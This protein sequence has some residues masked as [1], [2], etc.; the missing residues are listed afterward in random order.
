M[1]RSVRAYAAVHR[2][3]SAL[4]LLAG[5]CLVGLL[6]ANVVLPS[7]A[8]TRGLLVALALPCACGVA[9]AFALVNDAPVLTPRRP[10]VVLARLGWVAVTL[11]A[12][13]VA[14]SVCAASSPDV[15]VAAVAR[16]VLISWSLAVVAVLVGQDELAWVIPTLVL[17]ASVLFSTPDPDL[18][19]EQ[20]WGLLLNKRLLAHDAAIALMFACPAAV[21]AVAFGDRKLPS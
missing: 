11:T 13:V 4:A 1:V 5:L 21:L 17:G 12:A 14:G 10:R 6:V 9:G 7:V 20:W 2:S 19:S 16:N 18:N 8:D 15:T 3:K